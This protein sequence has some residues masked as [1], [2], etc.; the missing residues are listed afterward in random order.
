M[1]E[2][3]HNHLN[4]D[5]LYSMYT[6]AIKELEGSYRTFFF[7]EMPASDE[8]R[9]KLL[10]HLLGTSIS[11]GLYILNYLHKVMLLEG[12][13]CEFG[14]AQGF[15]SALLAYEIQ[16]TDKNIWLFDSFQGL[17]KPSSKDKLI[18][19]FWNLGSIEAYEGT[20]ACPVSMVKERLREIEFPYERVKIIPGFIDKAICN[21]DNC[22]EKVCFAYVDF[23]FYEPILIALN[24]LNKAL[25]NGGYIVV[26]DYGYFS[27]GAKTAV[28]EFFEVNKHDYNLICP[29]EA[30]GH[31][32]ILEKKG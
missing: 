31:F 19:D 26:D 21:P 22:P 15:T 1:V 30:A 6:S 8:T 7:K 29:I 11:E 12:D 25:Q 17:P 20:M 9:I 13:I 16:K 5:L 2:L 32:C 24:F 27:A 10:S 28:D 3:K 14:V 23:D 4:F 18:D